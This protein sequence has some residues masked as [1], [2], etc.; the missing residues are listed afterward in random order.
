[1]VKSFG[2]V[3]VAAAGTPV[4]ASDNLTLATGQPVPLQ[5]V[6]FQ[7]HP[8]NTGKV[9]IFVEMSQPPADH[10]TDGVGLVAILPAPSDPDT[11]P[12]PSGTFG[13]PATPNGINLTNFWLDVQTS[14]DKVIVSGTVG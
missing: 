7:A 2:I 1:M 9:Y 5:A 14:G 8:D 10:R 4:Q 11:G 13:L 6:L 3:T 12:F